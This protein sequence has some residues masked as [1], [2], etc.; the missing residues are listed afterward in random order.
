MTRILIT[1]KSSYIGTS[2]ER[3][4]K[5]Y[6]EYEIDM[7]SVRGDEW[8]DEDFSDYD[9][10]FHV[11]GLAHA[12]VGTISKE[13]QQKYYDINCDL[14]VEVAEKYKQ[15]RGGKESQFIYMSSII[16]YGDQ[17][18]MTK[19]RVI[20]PLTKPKPSNFYGDSKLQAELKLA[21]LESNI[22]QLAI[23]RPPM[24]YGPNSKGNY[25]QL[26]KLALKLPVF[27]DIPNERSMLFVDNLSMF[28]K[29]II[30]KHESGIFFPQNME[31]V[32]TSHM[33]KEIARF[34][35]KDIKLF[36]WMNWSVYLLGKIPGKIGDLSNKAFGNLVYEKSD[37]FVGVI[38]MKPSIERTEKC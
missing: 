13:E 25:P 9:V 35:G 26:R 16:I 37:K 18:S 28:I 33:V 14:S 6:P 1:G 8:K 11:A 24:I 2:F 21:P 19:K 34:H 3:Y 20:T 17:V 23:I 15:D 12:D 10:V 7:I 29:Q 4:M 31:Y 30:D 32:R 36:S 27:P 38:E 5:D 22:F